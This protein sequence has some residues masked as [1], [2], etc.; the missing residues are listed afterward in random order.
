MKHIAL[1]VIYLF[2]VQANAENHV[3]TERVKNLSDQQ[4][5]ELSD[6]SGKKFGLYAP[7][8]YFLPDKVY[9]NT[10]IFNPNGTA[11]ISEDYTGYDYTFSWTIIDGS[12]L[13][14]MNRDR[15]YGED[16]DISCL[17]NDSC[18]LISYREYTVDILLEEGFILN[19]KVYTV[20]DEGVSHNIPARNFQIF[21]EIK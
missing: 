9:Y 7:E 19:R 3:V 2:V 1:I 10:V 6:F 15:D 16:N 4:K 8:D 12:K 21:K 13:V 18:R 17:I 5:V 20:D 14:L 11:V